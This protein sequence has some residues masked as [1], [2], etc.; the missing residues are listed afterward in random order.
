MIDLIRA[1]YGVDPDTIVGGPNWLA[2][3]RFDISAKTD[4][5]ARQPI[6]R[7]MLQ[8]L[9]ADR[10]KLALHKDTR[11]MP[12]FAL[13]IGKTKP[14]LK[15]SD[16]TGDSG[17]VYQPQPGGA[18]D[19][20]YA[21]RNLT[22]DAF[23]EQ[24]H[25]FAGDYL[26]SPVVNTTGLDGTYEFDLRWNRRSQVLPSGTERT[27]IF[28]AVEKQLG[29][30][31]APT[32]TPAPVVVV[33]RVNENPT[34]NSP[35]TAQRLPPRPVEFEVVDLKMNR[36]NEQSY[37]NT[38]PGGG[39]EARGVE[40]KIL[41][42][43]GWDMDWDHVDEGFA[44]LPRWV[45]GARVDIHAKPPSYTNNP[46]PAGAGFMDDDVRLILKNLLIER[47]QIETHIENRPKDAYTLVA[48][49][50]KLKKADPSNR[51]NCK[52]ARTIA[53]DPR[54]ANPL[55]ARLISCQNVTMAQFAAALHGFGA[56]YILYDVEDATGLTSAYDF[57]LSYTPK[58]LLAAAAE[59]SDPTG[60]ISLH[61]AIGKQLG[62]K[63]EMRKR[64][65]PVVVIDRMEEMPLAN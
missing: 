36:N 23:A 21:C 57:T 26:T 24:I 39:L 37:I 52:D 47:F 42:A 62:L 22:M 53:N 13:T 14:R 18:V 4:P 9:L 31:L 55:L 29:L 19:T 32:K 43:S 50:P 15:A 48:A 46:P 63:L 16:G 44:N 30:T 58:Y 38:T 3:D 28:D 40:M 49:K 33:D 59:A 2:F 54:D 65:L 12:A 27:T 34:A 6:V 8:S 64:P 7:L 20:V 60:A 5:G 1:A 11:P 17:C 41:L 51:A 35:D 10:F 61:D 25:G 56:D 45:D